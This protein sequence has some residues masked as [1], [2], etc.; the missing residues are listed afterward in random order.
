MNALTRLLITALLALSAVTASAHPNHGSVTPITREDASL[1]GERIVN[2]L[3][4]TKKLPQSWREKQPA[5]VS[6]RQAPGGA[7]V[8]V[9]RYENPEESD[10]SKRTI[11]IFFDEY[12]NFLGGNY[13]GK[14]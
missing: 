4:E 9:V 6:T 10:G 8:W 1:L 5:D 2:M 12:G 14:M 7:S 11:Y 13:S 3:I